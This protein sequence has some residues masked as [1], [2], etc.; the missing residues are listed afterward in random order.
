MKSTR[1]GFKVALTAT[2]VGL[3]ILGVGASIYIAF[4]TLADAVLLLYIMLA[5]VS[6]LLWIGLMIKRIGGLYAVLRQMESVLNNTAGSAGRSAPLIRDIYR[7]VTGNNIND[8]AMSL[9]TS[10]K[11]I[12]LESLQKLTKL[13]SEREMLESQTL[14]QIAA[15]ARLMRIYLERA[16]DK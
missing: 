9:T 15:E 3:L 13:L 11:T 10:E 5:S 8:A 6:I 2:I 12:D 1:S 7:Y 16:G 4:T 14:R